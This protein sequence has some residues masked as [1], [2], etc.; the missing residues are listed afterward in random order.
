MTNDKT[1]QNEAAV[2]KA[3]TNYYGKA[4]PN[5]TNATK[6]DSDDEK[7]SN[8]STEHHILDSFDLDAYNKRQK[9]KRK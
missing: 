7:E 1:T 5:K 8:E 2:I 4:Q 3:K 6:L 9:R